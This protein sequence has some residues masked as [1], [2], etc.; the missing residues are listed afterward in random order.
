MEQ[1]T[2]LLER[3]Y[4]DLSTGLVRFS[5][6]GRQ[7][8]SISG[9]DRV[10][11][12]QRM[13]AQDVGNLERGS[14]REAV[15]LDKEGRIQAVLL[16]CALDETILLRVEE[17][18]APDLRVLLEKYK[19]VSKIT[20]DGRPLAWE[21]QSLGGSRAADLIAKIVPE[22]G[23]KSESPAVWSLDTPA[24]PGVVIR[25]D[26]LGFPAFE[27]WTPPQAD[28]TK[29]KE[30][31]FSDL[32]LVSSEAVKAHQIESLW[33]T[34]L[35]EGQKPLIPNECGQLGSWVSFEK[36]CYPGQEVVVRIQ[37]RGHPGRRLV[38]LSLESENG[39]SSGQLK[40]QKGKPVG[41]C[42]LSGYCPGL[43]S[44]GA[45]AMVRYG[46]H[47]PGTILELGP[48]ALRVEV[49]K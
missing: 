39:F 16:V 38:L 9:P 40:S 43:E 23:P 8:L 31:T 13:L 30:D 12:L 4:K 5:S 21:C 14:A 36:G 22:I 26:R 45:M 28:K 27:I 33:P 32:E 11:F 41:E 29:Y 44:F 7:I 34:L 19:V 3:D 47:E 17:G 15:I 2:S 48:D 46:S 49:L 18:R 24:G 20:I 6:P 42:V 25:W 1:G 37:H 35:Q 10:D